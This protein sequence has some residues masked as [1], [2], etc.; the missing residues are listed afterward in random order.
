MTTTKITAALC[1]DLTV[2]ALKMGNGSE[3]T[4]QIQLLSSMEFCRNREIELLKNA[5][6]LFSTQ[7]EIYI[8]L[9]SLVTNFVSNLLLYRNETR[10]QQYA[11]DT[12]ISYSQSICYRSPSWSLIVWRWVSFHQYMTST[13]SLG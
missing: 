3:N 11:D 10:I 9:R 2:F 6:F 5:H 4:L 7:T 13:I 1:N 12:V 8:K